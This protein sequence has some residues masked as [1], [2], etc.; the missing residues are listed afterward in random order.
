MTPPSHDSTAAERLGPGGFALRRSERT[1]I[2]LSRPRLGVGTLVAACTALAALS[3]LWPSTP[4]YDPWAWL[5][6][7]REVASGHLSTLNGPS[8]PVGSWPW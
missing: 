4:T 8:W 7:G 5:I 2:A 1:S 6:W 3:L